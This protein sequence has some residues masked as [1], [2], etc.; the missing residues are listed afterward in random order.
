MY[1]LHSSQHPRLFLHAARKQR[2]Q[3]G[4]GGQHSVGQKPVQGFQSGIHCPLNGGEERPALGR[5]GGP[6]G[7]QKFTKM[8]LSDTGCE[9]FPAVVTFIP[10]LPFAIEVVPND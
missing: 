5:R 4:N 10:S 9:G 6:D 7:E 2:T 3:S 1:R 8:P